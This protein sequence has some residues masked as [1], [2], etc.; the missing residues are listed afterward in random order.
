[1]A[2]FRSGYLKQ[3]DPLGM[4]QRDYTMPK[5]TRMASP[6]WVDL[7]GVSLAKI[8]GI[9]DQS[10]VDT[11]GADGLDASQA[12]VTGVVTV[13]QVGHKLEVGSRIK[14]KGCSGFAEN[15]AAMGSNPFQAVTAVTE[16]TF[17]YVGTAPAAP[18]TGKIA[19]TMDAIQTPVKLV[20]GVQKNQQVVLECANQSTW[21]LDTSNIDI[22]DAWI[23]Q[24][25]DTLTL[26]WDGH[27]KWVGLSDQIRS[28]ED[29]RYQDGVIYADQM[30]NLGAQDLV[31]L[32]A[33]G[34]GFYNKIDYVQMDHDAYPAAMTVND[35]AAVAVGSAVAPISTTVT[36][37]TVPDHGLAVG[38]I[39]VVTR[40]TGTLTANVTLT[41]VVTQ[42]R[43]V[44]TTPGAK[45]FTYDVAGI[46]SSGTGTI[47]YTVVQEITD[48]NNIRMFPS[49]GFNPVGDMYPTNDLRPEFLQST[50]STGVFFVPNSRDSN[51]IIFGSFYKFTR[52]DPAAALGGLQTIDLSNKEYLIKGVSTAT[53]GAAGA[54]AMKPTGTIK[55]QL[56][57]H[58]IRYR[59]KYQ[60]KSVTNLE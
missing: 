41:D 46:N 4:T 48:G 35:A 25:F 8:Y 26:Y 9:E 34:A 29:V 27:S 14:I 47:D 30:E 24:E 6:F 39:I 42:T 33:P 11:V 12:A 31:L 32:P 21:H 55:A 37:T 5:G 22:L 10:S 59:I 3:G 49:S 7:E 53:G 18:G 56:A 2:N 1:M 13:T 60:V 57:N 28:D 58:R 16:T 52:I 17:S 43:V 15:G 38:D 23:P 50:G 54:A 51:Q 20:D 44:A 19:Y 45:E 40:A 36:V